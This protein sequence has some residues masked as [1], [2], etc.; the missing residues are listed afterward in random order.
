[1]RSEALTS[2]IEHRRQPDPSWNSMRTRDVSQWNL[3]S[4]PS[5]VSTMGSPE[6]ES[7]V[8]SVGGIPPTSTKSPKGT[9]LA[10][11]M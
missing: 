6:D 7:T 3:T 9:H 2:S 10:G 8:Q 5:R 1:M 11:T 4:V